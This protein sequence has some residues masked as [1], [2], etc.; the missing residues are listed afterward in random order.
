MEKDG[1]KGYMRDATDTL[2]YLP[3]ASLSKHYFNFG[4][5]DVDVEN[6][7]QRI[8]RSICL[9]NH[10]HSNLLIIWEKGMSGRKNLYTQL[11]LF[12]DFLI[13]FLYRY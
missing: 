8:P 3:P 4:Q 5:V 6:I 1:F 10:I 11:I 13:Y 12:I 9:T 2:E 7:I